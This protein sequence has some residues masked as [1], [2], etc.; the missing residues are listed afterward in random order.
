VVR[1]PAV[2]TGAGVAPRAVAFGVLAAFVAVYYATSDSWWSAS[3]WWDVAFLALV[4]IPSVFALVLLVLPLWR[5]R[6]LLA[7]ALA[8]AVLAIL[9]Q[10]AGL[11]APSGFAKLAAVTFAG[12]WF[13]AYFEKASWLVL[14]ALIIPFVDAYSVWRGPTHQIVE[15]QKQLFTTL[16]FAFPLPGE[17]ASANLGLPDLLFF[18]LFLSASARFL[19]RPTFTWVCMALSFGATLA[20]AVAF[21]VPGLPALPL[22]SLAFLL[23]NADL[24]WP[25]IAK[26]RRRLPT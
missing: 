1:A 14:V 5:A 3:N 13:L 7:T 12:F 18:A 8:L 24:L 6:G 17:H 22:L 11:E 26:R 2:L 9:L 19:L 21:D 10:L 4:L 16:S 15:H 25:A 20:L 23:P